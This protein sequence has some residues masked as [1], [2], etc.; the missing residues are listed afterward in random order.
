MQIY[1]LI[2]NLGG[3]TLT[4]KYILLLKE[5]IINSLTDT[6]GGSLKEFTDQLIQQNVNF[7]DDILLAYETVSEELCGKVNV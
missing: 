1:N 6:T 7:R 2:K 3:I 5:H 4:E